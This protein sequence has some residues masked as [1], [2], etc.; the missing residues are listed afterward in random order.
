MAT[1]TEA[2]RS[3]RYRRAI[4]RQVKRARRQRERR[5]RHRH[6]FVHGTIFDDGQAIITCTTCGHEELA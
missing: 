1:F 2:V 3:I 6:T 5:Q 4:A